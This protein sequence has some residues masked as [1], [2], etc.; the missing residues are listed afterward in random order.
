MDELIWEFRRAT[1]DDRGLL[2]ERH[3]QQLLSLYTKTTAMIA[4]I[5]R[6]PSLRSF[7]PLI[8]SVK[9]VKVTNLSFKYYADKLYWRNSKWMVRE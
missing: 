8:P 4:A 1:V 6:L 9:K 5:S 2:I 3:F 7:Y